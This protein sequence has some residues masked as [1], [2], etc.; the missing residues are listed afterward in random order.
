[1]QSNVLTTL[2]ATSQELRLGWYTTLVRYKAI[3]DDEPMPEEA[4]R[5]SQSEEDSIHLGLDEPPTVQKVQKQTSA[6]QPT[7]APQPT[8]PPQYQHNQQQSEYITRSE[9][10]SLFN[11]LMGEIR[12]LRDELKTYRDQRTREEVRIEDIIIRN[13]M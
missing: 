10:I 3:V 6:S 1:M 4:T 9:M 8:S 2:A 13:I 11:D 5:Q 12:A 7:P